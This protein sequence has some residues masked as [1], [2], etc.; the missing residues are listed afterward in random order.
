MPALQL[1][2]PLDRAN[3]GISKIRQAEMPALQVDESIR[4]AFRNFDV[5]R[6]NVGGDFL[7][8]A[9]RGL[10]IDYRA[11]HAAIR[12]RSSAAE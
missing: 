1:L 6:G 8:I 7:Q 4:K 2:R 12:E 10:G 9:Q 3:F 11:V 5:I